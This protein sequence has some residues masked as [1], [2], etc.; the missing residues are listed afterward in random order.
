MKLSN[1]LITLF[2][3][4]EFTSANSLATYTGQTQPFV[5]GLLS[6]DKKESM[7][8]MDVVFHALTEDV[9]VDEFMAA[10]ELV[11]TVRRNI[12]EKDQIL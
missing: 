3:A 11:T 8:K 12:I 4:S 2:N 9:T 1:L 6:P 10:L 5:S 7:E